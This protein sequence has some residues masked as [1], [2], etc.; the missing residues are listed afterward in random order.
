MLKIKREKKKNNVK[1]LKP[2]GNVIVNVSV[3]ENNC[4][5]NT[6]RY[7]KLSSPC[8]VLKSILTGEF[9]ALEMKRILV[10][11]VNLFPELKR[12]S[13]INRRSFLIKLLSS[14]MYFFYKDPSLWIFNQRR[15]TKDTNIFTSTEIMK[16][17]K[18]E[19]C[20]KNI[21]SL[22]NLIEIRILNLKK[23]DFKTA[24]EFVPEKSILGL[25]QQFKY[26]LVYNGDFT[27]LEN[28]TDNLFRV[29][30]G[31]FYE[32]VECDVWIKNSELLR[33]EDFGKK[34]FIQTVLHL[35]PQTIE[36]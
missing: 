12:T 14:D 26:R 29:K 33:M 7:S 23:E 31:Y 32:A 17:S 18:C 9:S 25:Y 1:V 13:D 5:K 36:I 30:P 34:T 11:L 19:M 28:L 3:I 10:D 21:D 16:N 20:V 4:K 6:F 35:N 27:P 2:D 8:G 22:N 15:F 24:F